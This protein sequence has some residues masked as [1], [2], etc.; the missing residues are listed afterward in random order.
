VITV[1]AEENQGKTSKRKKA[2]KGRR[3]K[4][5]GENRRKKKPGKKMQFQA[6]GFNTCSLRR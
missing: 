2:Q 5:F 3:K 1:I 4:R 6:G